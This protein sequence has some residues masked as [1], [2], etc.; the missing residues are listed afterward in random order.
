MK[1]KLFLLCAVSG[2]F[3]S[4]AFSASKTLFAPG[5][6]ETSGWYDTNK[7]FNSEDSGL[8]WAATASNVIAWWL[9]TYRRGGGDLSGVPAQKPADIF[10]AFKTN[11][12]NLGYDNAAGVNWYFTGK[13]SS[14]SAPEELEIKNSGGYLKHLDG[15]GGGNAAWG[16]LNEIVGDWGV[17]KT[18][19]AFLNNMSGSYYENEPLYSLESFSKTIINQLSQGAAMLSVHQPNALVSSTGHS[20]TL[21]GCEYDEETKLVSKIFITDSDDRYNG[22]KSF[23]IVEP[24][25]GKSGV[26]MDNYWV[27]AYRYGSI[28]SS[29]MM[30]SA[31]IPE[32]SAFALLA[33]A[34]TLLV[35]ISRRRRK[36]SH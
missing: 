20:I 12:A 13:F 17:W 26:V 6:S 30:Y 3:P 8:C 2:F 27:D 16:P 32:P 9:D 4:L 36:T 7:A 21:W 11:W 15:V 31:Y 35:V 33:G 23:S 34:G 14:G 10:Q 19:K 28:T 29:V 24:T 22:L 25:N 18:K 5:V 1:K